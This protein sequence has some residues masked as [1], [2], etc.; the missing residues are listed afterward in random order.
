MGF[1]FCHNIVQVDQLGF[2][3]CTLRYDYFSCCYRTYFKT[4]PFEKF[5]VECFPNFKTFRLSLSP[6]S[7]KT[8]ANTIAIEKVACPP[9]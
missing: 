1:N 6:C 3:P 2:F 7:I 9:L 5:W 4:H 8:F